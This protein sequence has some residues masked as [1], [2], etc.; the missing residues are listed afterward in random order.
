MRVPQM[1]LMLFAL[2]LAGCGGA[3]RTASVHMQLTFTTDRFNPAVWRIPGGETIQIQFSNQTAVEHEWVLL[4][5][6]PIEPFDAAEEAQVLARFR[7]APGETRTAQ[8]L[9]PSAPG[10]YGVTCSIPGHLESGEMGKVVVVQ[11]GY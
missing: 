6:P 2:L 7:V 3:P 9:A 11:P 4:K 8:F 5:D 10:E 1:L